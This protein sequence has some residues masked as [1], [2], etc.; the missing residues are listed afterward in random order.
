[1]AETWHTLTL[2]NGWS[3]TL[4]YPTGGFTGEV[5]ADHQ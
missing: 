4:K 1:V 2:A 3:G 5:R